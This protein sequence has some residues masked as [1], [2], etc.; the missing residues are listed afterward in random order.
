MTQKINKAVHL[1]ASLSTSFLKQTKEYEDEFT[2][3]SFGPA[4]KAQIGT[5]VNTPIGADKFFIFVG[6]YEASFKF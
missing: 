4:V 2:D 1:L 6:G 5:E 3:T